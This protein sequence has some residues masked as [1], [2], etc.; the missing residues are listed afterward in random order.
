MKE[1]TT[2]TREELYELVWSTPMSSLATKYA[3]SD[4]G[5]K[6]LCRRHHIPTPPRGYWAQQEAGNAPARPRLPTT[7]N[8][9]AIVLRVAT[10]DEHVA[11][12]QDAL[13]LAIEEAKRPENRVRVPDR[14]RSPSEPVREAKELLDAATP[15]DLGILESPP[16]CLDIRV[17]RAQLPRALR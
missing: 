8:R 17:S 10:T 6:K 9:S 12:L 4:V 2:L 15:D 7:Q 3:I 16:G 11:G 13:T 14:L 1:T 5:L